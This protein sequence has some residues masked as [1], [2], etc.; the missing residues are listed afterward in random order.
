M[1][2]FNTAAR[3][4]ALTAITDT[5]AAGTL[6]IYAGITALATH[7]MAGWAAAANGSR[8]AN[9]IANDTVD[10]TGTA[11]SAK[12]ISGTNEITLSV[13]TTGTEVVMTSL[14]LTAGGTSSISS[15]TVTYPAS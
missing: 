2:S 4:T 7:T 10:A 13:G 15:V 14:S 6:V 3:N 1:P 8:S 5:Y 9:A 11:D 12:L